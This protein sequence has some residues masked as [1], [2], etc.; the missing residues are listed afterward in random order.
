MQQYIKHKKL[1][2]TVLLAPAVV[3]FTVFVFITA[4]ANIVLS[5]TDWNGVGAIEFNGLTNWAK[6]AGDKDYWLSFR[7]TDVYKRQEC[8]Q[9]T[10]DRRA[11][12]CQTSKNRGRV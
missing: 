9:R 8:I 1:T 4:V 10:T 7:N 2:L 6:L 11:R 5:F 12:P 3:F